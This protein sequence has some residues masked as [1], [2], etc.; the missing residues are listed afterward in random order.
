LLTDEQAAS[1]RAYFA[2]QREEI[3][4]EWHD[5]FC[6]LAS[7]LRERAQECDRRAEKLSEGEG[8]Y[9]KCPNVPE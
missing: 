2:R 7:T 5:Y 4:A 8:V 3:R 1:E 9:S 6:R